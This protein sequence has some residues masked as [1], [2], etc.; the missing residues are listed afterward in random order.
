MINLSVII[1]TKNEE[2]NIKFVLETVKFADEIIIVD[3]CSTDK[4]AKIARKYGAKVYIRKWPGYF[5][6]KSF[7]LSKAKSKWVLAL[8]ADEIVT[9]ELKTEI[10]NAVKQN[11]FSGF[12]IN[13]ANYFL[14][15]FIK[16]CGWFPDF[17]IRLFK[18]KNTV[19]IDRAVHEGFK[20]E[21]KVGKLNSVL[22]H[23][24]YNT[25][26]QYLTKQNLY[27]SLEVKNIVKN[28]SNRKIK[29]FNFIFNP[30][31]TFLRMYFSNSGWRDGIRG[32]LLSSYSSLYCLL[33]YAKT[34]E[35]QYKNKIEKE[36][37]NAKKLLSLKEN[38]Q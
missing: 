20:V 4:T 11:E 7:A 36:N 6:Q 30:L 10:L 17:Q 19:L 24:T 22:N 21:G 28:N 3:A 35:V 13:R 9:T 15:N 32:F 5:L 12:E 14:G 31:S 1:I 38:I 37:L 29:W 26:E 16:H 23:Y 18:R 34:W 33:K 2:K 27:T 8:D 25:I